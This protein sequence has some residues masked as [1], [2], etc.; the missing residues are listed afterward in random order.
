MERRSCL[1]NGFLNPS[2]I[3]TAD[4]MF[5]NHFPQYSLGSSGGGN[6]TLS[7]S[8]GASSMPPPLALS[9]PQFL[10]KHSDNTTLPSFFS[11]AAPL[12]QIAP[13]AVLPFANNCNNSDNFKDSLTDFLI[14]CD[15]DIFTGRSGE[16]P[17]QEL[18]VGDSLTWSAPQLPTLE[19]R[20]TCSIPML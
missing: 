12:P 13:A 8:P 19:S 9:N 20:E 15:Q 4:D 2:S 17:S 18:P 6:S 14:A 7:S 11:T 16:L 5:L 1:Q 3:S 10:S